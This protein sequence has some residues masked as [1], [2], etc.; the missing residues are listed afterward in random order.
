MLVQPDRQTTKP[1]RRER[2]NRRENP[3]V[4]ALQLIGIFVLVRGAMLGTG[5]S[6]FHIPF[7]DPSLSRGLGYML[8][9]L[10]R[11]AG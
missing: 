10:E 6:F 8:S 4:V 9:L 1:S 11:F 3:V 7:I 5:M 2:L